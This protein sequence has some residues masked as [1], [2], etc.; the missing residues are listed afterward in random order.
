MKQ[1]LLSNRARLAFAHDMIMTGL[2]VPAAL[3]LRMGGDFTTLDLNEVLLTSLLYMLIA[4]P[5]YAGIG[6]YRGIWR[7]ASMSDLLT[8]TKAV[9]L[10]SLIFLPVLFSLT[11]LEW[12][13]RSFPVINW[14]LLITVLC[15]ARAAYRMLKDKKGLSILNASSEP[16]IP[17]LLLGAGNGTDLFLREL[18]EATSPLY[19]AVG[20]LA[21]DEKRVGLSIQGVPIIAAIGDLDEGIFEKLSDR[22]SKLI[23][24]KEN[25]DGVV[26]RDTFEKAQELGLTVARASKIS[27]LKDGLEETAIEGIKPIAVEDLLGRAQANLDRPAMKALV[28]GKRVLITGAG[29]SI[30]S[31]LVRQITA[32]G[33]SEITLLDS[34]EYQLY[35]IDREISESHP[36]LQRHAV[37]ADIRDKIRINDIFGRLKP[38]LVF[39][40][41]ALKHVPMV[42]N[43]PL[44][45]ILTNLVG[46]RTIADACQ[47]ANVLCM[48]QISTDKAVNPTNVM[49]ATKRLA[50]CYIQAL[51]PIS[52]SNN[53][54]KFVAVRFGNVL[55]STGSV[56]PL[57]QRQLAK[58][59]PLTVT[60]PEVNRFFMTIREAVELVLQAS[61]LGSQDASSAGK[62]YVLEMGQAVKIADLARQIILLAGKRPDIDIEIKYT[63][64]RPGEKLYEEV[65]HDDETQVATSAK[66][67]LL[68]APRTYEFEDLAVKLDSLAEAATRRDRKLCL[69]KLQELIPEYEGDAATLNNNDPVANIATEST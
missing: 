66:G 61:V 43:N 12:L 54:T 13:P 45:G 16:L 25:P 62:I 3:L 33:P 20:I 69:Q 36:D 21:F 5:V 51:D 6:M 29:G 11:R 28:H 31:E 34:S 50:E 26:I 15:G 63:G 40:A 53:S 55:G 41:A 10:T 22:P 30:G 42:E 24:T 68:A 46:S 32:Q 64:L 60:H 19:K 2:S 38:E 4:L 47:K 8:V 59:G 1:L 44:E 57:F 48:V 23:L 37:L 9:T 65:L 67:I 14:F 39:H 58:G 7:F 49:G 18:R 52:R 17:V 56:V 35:L 27:E